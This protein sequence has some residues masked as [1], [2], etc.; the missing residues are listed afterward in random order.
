M[1]IPQ[2]HRPADRGRDVAGHPHIKWQAGAAQ[3]GAELPAAQE[4]GEPARTGQQAD[5]LFDNRLFDQ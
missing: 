2:D 3:A 1:L 5:G 4:R